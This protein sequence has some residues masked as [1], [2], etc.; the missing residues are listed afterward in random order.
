LQNYFCVQVAVVATVSQHM[1]EDGQLVVRI[2]SIDVD[3]K[4]LDSIETPCRQENV[5][6]MPSLKNEVVNSYG[7]TSDLGK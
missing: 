6:E 3:Q 5:I 7:L 2:E 4:L 1:D